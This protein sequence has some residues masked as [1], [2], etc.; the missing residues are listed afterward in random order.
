[1]RDRLIAGALVPAPVVAQAQKFRRWYR[2][3]VLRLFESVDAIL[4]PATPCVAPQIGQK[5]FVLN[6]QE[7]PVRPNIGLYTQPI[8]FIG[9]PVVAVPVPTLS[10]TAD[11]R[12]D[13]HRRLARGPRAAHRPS[14]GSR[15]RG[16]HADPGVG[17]LTME[18]NLPDVKHEVEAA[19]A[20]YET[21]LVSNDV[22][23]LQALFWDSDRTI[24]Y[25]IGGNPLRL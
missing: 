16:A 9:L 23:T 7:M 13:H 11:R 21:A 5:T 20:R 2:G 24:R 12:A 8:S 15:G 6:G 22:D 14:A 3:A 10:G 25:G 19:F 17:W 18:I 1:M 4:A